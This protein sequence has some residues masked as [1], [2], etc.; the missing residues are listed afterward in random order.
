VGLSVTGALAGTF[1]G[2]NRD[3][4]R[5]GV[6]LTLAVDGGAPV[7]GP[8][9]LTMATTLK[10]LPMG[11]KPF[12]PPRDGMKVL[13]IDAPPHRLFRALPAVVQGRSPE[14]FAEA[15][16]RRHDAE[17]L[18]IHIDE[19]LVID[20]EVFVGGEIIVRRGAPV[21]FLAP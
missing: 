4:W 7:A 2:G 14:W 8:R 5:R 3:Q 10:R 18:V 9:F 13:D 19:G 6:E 12:G 17:E 11:L 16:Y 21:R 1:L 20:G 15:G